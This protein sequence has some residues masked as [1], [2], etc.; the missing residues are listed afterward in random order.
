M[1]E[2][3]WSDCSKEEREDVSKLEKRKRKLMKYISLGY[4]SAQGEEYFKKELDK[5]IKKTEKKWRNDE[6]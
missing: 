4:L 1:N 6:L 2:K 5:E 3:Y